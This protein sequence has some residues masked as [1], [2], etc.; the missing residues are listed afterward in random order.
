MSDLGTLLCSWCLVS[1]APFIVVQL[2]FSLVMI[3][4]SKEFVGC[5]RCI[6]ILSP[7]EVQQMGEEGMQLLN[8]AGLQGINGST[9]EYPN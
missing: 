7:T 1:Y 6:R 2:Y 3:L 8:S 4:E 9:S 5:V